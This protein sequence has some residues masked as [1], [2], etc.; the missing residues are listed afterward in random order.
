MRERV[1]YAVV[2]LRYAVAYVGGEVT[3]TATTFILYASHHL[4]DKLQEVGATRVRVAKGALDKYLR[5]VQILDCPAH[6][7]LQRVIFGCQRT[8]ALAIQVL[9]HSSIFY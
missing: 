9:C 7:N 2:T 1:V 5:A 4:I 6:T 3:R 8:H